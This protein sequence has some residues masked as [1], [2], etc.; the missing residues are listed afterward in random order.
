MTDPFIAKTVQNPGL[1]GHLIQAF[2][3]VFTSGKKGVMFSPF[4]SPEIVSHR[5]IL[6]VRVVRRRHSC[7]M[8]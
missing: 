3:Y 4:V 2:L 8:C 7:P 1:L 6:G 5:T